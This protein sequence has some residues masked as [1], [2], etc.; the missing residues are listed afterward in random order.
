MG[1]LVF[2]FGMTRSISGDGPNFIQG[3]LHGQQSWVN[4][5]WEDLLNFTKSTKFVEYESG[6]DVEA[7]FS[8]SMD[9]AKTE[10]LTKEEFEDFKLLLSGY[11]LLAI[12]K[13]NDYVVD[14]IFEVL[15]K[16]M[17][18]IGRTVRAESGRVYDLAKLAEL[19]R[20]KQKEMIDPEEDWVITAVELYKTIVSDFNISRAEKAITIDGVISLY[21]IK[22]V[23]LDFMFPGIRETPVTQ[24]IM[25]LLDVLSE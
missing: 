7:T 8:E 14:N 4:S 9:L 6:I 2:L 10:Y 20:N 12:G 1:V 22:G 13:T 11:Y 21:H 3:R 25:I 18:T 5:A 19:P 23:F 24:S 15:S 17:I 16:Y